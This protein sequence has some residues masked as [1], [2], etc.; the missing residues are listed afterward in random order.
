MNNSI[1]SNDYYNKNINVISST[2]QKNAQCQP[3]IVN[4]YQ[5]ILLNI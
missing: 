1:K 3:Q 2:W 4:A 5:Y